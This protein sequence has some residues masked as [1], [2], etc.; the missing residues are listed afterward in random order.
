MHFRSLNIWLVAG[1]LGISAC[2]PHAIESNPSP[3]II[4]PAQFTMSGTGQSTGTRWYDAFHDQTLNGLIETAF[5]SNLDVQQAR[6]RLLQAGFLTDA[7]SAGRLPQLGATAQGQ[8]QKIEGDDRTDVAGIG[9]A[10]NWEIDAFNRIGNQ[11]TASK[12]EEEAARADIEA[13]RLSL[14]AEM[15]EAYFNAIADKA[16]LKLLRLQSESDNKS[17]DLIRQRHDAGIGTQ[18]EVLQQQSVLADTEALIPVA[19]ASLRMFENR[20]DVLT[21]AAPDGTDRVTQDDFTTIGDVPPVGVPS[22]LLLKRP[23]LLALKNRLVAQDA[24]IGAAIADRLPH[25]TL[26]GTTLLSS[27]GSG[28]AA[29]AVAALVQPLLDWGARKAEVERNKALYQEYL[30]AF[31]QAYLSAIEDV[32][33]TLYREQKQRDYIRLLEVRRGLLSNTLDAA[34][35]VYRSGESDYLP[36]LTA[37]RDLHSV[38]RELVTQRLNLVLYRIRLHRALGGS[39]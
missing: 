21:G 34:N 23:D 24:E 9:A 29:S 18:V 15:A 33:N 20:L 36:V 3:G 13:V 17:L 14:S 27:G 26:S 2:A 25:I 11:I 8:V 16:R 10:L 31:T 6:A 19:E 35:A 5:I 22:D 32:E 30:A 7:L 37:V 12:Y 39:L 38:E 28:Y 4:A 1:V